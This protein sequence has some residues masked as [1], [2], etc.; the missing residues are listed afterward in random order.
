[1]DKLDFLGTGMPLF[2]QYGCFLM[3]ALLVGVL[4]YGAYA[5]T[6]A[7][8]GNNCEVMEKTISGYCGSGWKT[9]PSAGN[10]NYEKINN[11][12]K[13][14]TIGYFAL[15][16]LT[17]IFAFRHARKKESV[18]DQDHTSPGDFTIIITGLPRNITEEEVSFIF[19]NYRGGYKRA[20]VEKV[21]FAYY[22]GDYVKFTRLKQTKEKEIIINQ[23]K[24]KPDYNKINQCVRDRNEAEINLNVVKNRFKMN[25][26]LMFTGI[27]FLTFKT[28]QDTEMILDHWEIS[29]FGKVSLKYLKCL[30][31]CYKGEAEKIRGKVVIVDEAP[32]PKDI[33]WENLGT[34][35]REIILNR[36]GAALL[37]FVILGISFGI[38]LGLK[39]LQLNYL[40]DSSYNNFVKTLLNLGITLSITIVNSILGMMIRSLSATGKY[41]TVTAYNSAVAKRIAL[42]II[43]F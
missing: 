40:K 18:L 31:K 6:Y 43:S 33:L 29:S 13:I 10:R 24:K 39:Y 35:T 19:N 32:E 42:V 30:K 15:L 36:I 25:S 21:N 20:E 9:L 28:Q 5:V 12:E 26:A 37:S 34:P 38:I 27:C 7:V 16:L 8:M 14:L 2:F 1:M 41:R 3:I 11:I 4:S 23:M 17:R 22:I